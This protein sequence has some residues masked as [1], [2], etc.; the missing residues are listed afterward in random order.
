MHA[1]LADRDK[2]GADDFVQILLGTFDDGRQASVFA[3]NPLGVQSDGALVETGTVPAA[4][5][6]TAPWCSGRPPI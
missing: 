3:V 5:G 1:T 6:S 4:T 2:I